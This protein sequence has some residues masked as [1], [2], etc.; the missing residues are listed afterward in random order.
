MTESERKA[1]SRRIAKQLVPGTF[2]QADQ[3]KRRLVKRAVL[4]TL[5]TIAEEAALLRDANASYSSVQL[6]EMGQ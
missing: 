3:Q 6:A 1:L 4:T 5:D 2:Y